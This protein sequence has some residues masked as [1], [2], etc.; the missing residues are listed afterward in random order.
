[1]KLRYKLGLA[2]LALA[3]LAAFIWQLDFFHTQTAGRYKDLTDYGA[4]Y[5]ATEELKAA[6]EEYAKLQDGTKILSRA[7][8]TGEKVIA[9]TFDGMADRGV[10]HGIAKVLDQHKM[11]AAFFMEG[12]NVAQE[13]KVADDIA[14]QYAIGNYSYVGLTH[15]ERMQPDKLLQELVRTQKV[16]KV[17]TGSAPSYFKLANTRYTPEVLK[18][19]KA[20]G[21]SYAVGQQTLL[22][23][24][25]I[26][27]EATADA[28][29][30]RLQPGTIVSFRLGIPTDIRWEEGKTDDRPAIDK[31]PNLKLKKWDNRKQT[32]RVTP[33]E[34]T[35]LLCDALQRA[36]YQTIHLM[37]FQPTAVTQL[38]TQPAPDK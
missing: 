20:S 2:L 24:G 18:V 13:P 7:P 33:V 11:T 12:S 16:L 38:S 8:E 1:M 34:E 30:A 26:Q 28:F 35:K 27:D 5:N 23:P 17:A 25:E 21:L 37:M 36:G 10:L 6:R 29:V 14:K 31:K 15:G 32:K 9:L 3:V 19:A 4:A 22:H